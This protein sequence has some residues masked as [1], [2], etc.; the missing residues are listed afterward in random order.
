MLAE[1]KL[2]IVRDVTDAVLFHIPAPNEADVLK[3]DVN[4]EPDT[5]PRIEVFMFV[6]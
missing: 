3:L 1:L 4:S 6:F 2:E 5:I